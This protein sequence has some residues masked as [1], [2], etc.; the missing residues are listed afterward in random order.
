MKVER[1]GL[2]FNIFL[3]FYDM[4]IQNVIQI[5]CLSLP[6][7]TIWNHNLK[8]KHLLTFNLITSWC[9]WHCKLLLWIIYHWSDFRYY[10]LN[11]C[12]YLGINVWYVQYRSLI[13]S[14]S[15]CLQLRA[16]RYLP[17]GEKRLIFSILIFFLLINFKWITVKIVVKQFTL[18]SI[19]EKNLN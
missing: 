8:T 7:V 2:V 9:L 12:H 1:F 6:L 4:T 14:F 19:F 13:I 3:S 15:I 17:I 5:F 16:I 18:F 10:N 11:Y